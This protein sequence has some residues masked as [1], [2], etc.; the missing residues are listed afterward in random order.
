MG[1]V[2][3]SVPTA[4]GGKCT[5]DLLQRVFFGGTR[6]SLPNT[7][8]APPTPLACT[9]GEYPCRSQ[10]DSI[11]YALGVVTGQA[12]Y[13]MGG[14]AVAYR[15][16][17]DSRLSALTVQADPDVGGAGSRLTAEEGMMKGTP[18]APPPP[19]V[20]PVVTTATANV[21][22]KARPGEPAPTVRYGSTVCR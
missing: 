21:V 7:R 12:A 14:D 20:P 2:E 5:G 22:F 19:G 10:F 8:F 4:G 17:R 13:Q 6:L 15:I 11:L 9:T 16:F 3:C 18:K 1:A